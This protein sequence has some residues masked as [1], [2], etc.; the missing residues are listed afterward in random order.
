PEPHS[1]RFRSMARLLDRGGG[2]R[3]RVLSDQQEE[4]LS[5]IPFPGSYPCR[6]FFRYSHISQKAISPISSP[7]NARRNQPGRF[8]TVSV[9]RIRY[10]KIITMISFMVLTIYFR[11]RYTCSL[12][13]SVT[14]TPV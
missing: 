13:F 3:C 14:S 6:G 9:C 11:V 5:V 2:Y 1:R 4:G 8:L 10:V 12:F 7:T